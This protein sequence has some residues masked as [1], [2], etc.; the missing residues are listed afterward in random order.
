MIKVFVK[1]AKKRFN[2][3]SHL[4]YLNMQ[5]S[6]VL[7]EKTHTARFTIETF[8]R[9]SEIIWW[10][11]EDVLRTFW[12]PFVGLLRTFWG[13]FDF[14]FI[15]LCMMSTIMH[16]LNLLGITCLLLQ[17]YDIYS[18]ERERYVYQK[19]RW[20]G[21]RENEETLVSNHWSLCRVSSLHAH[22]CSSPLFYPIDFSMTSHPTTRSCLALSSKTFIFWNFHALISNCTNLPADWT[23]LQFSW[24]H[25]HAYVAPLS[26]VKDAILIMF[27]SN[28]PLK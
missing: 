18:Q 20:E 28:V 19:S 22:F 3:K 26:Q 15:V 27:K 24:R 5:F 4:W 8:W 13:S 1:F 17:L 16:T 14:V 11:F 23:I 7:E 2:T 12:W 6:H 25:D 21:R 10:P 9:S